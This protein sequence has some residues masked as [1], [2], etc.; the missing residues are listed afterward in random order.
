[1]DASER[2]ISTVF[3]TPRDLGLRRMAV[4]SVSLGFS[5]SSRSTQNFVSNLCLTNS[6]L[7]SKFTVHSSHDFLQ[8]VRA[9]LPPSKQPKTLQQC[10]CV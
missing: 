5:S 9:P 8:Q 7:L 3:E 1:M 4:L 10:V 6:N 2:Y